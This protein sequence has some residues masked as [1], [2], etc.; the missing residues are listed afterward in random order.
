[1]LFD[2]LPELRQGA[3]GWQGRRFPTGNV[4]YITTLVTL[5]GSACARPGIR[6]WELGRLLVAG[7]VGHSVRLMCLQVCCNVS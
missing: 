1:M 7:H 3:A 4:Y 5:F 6:V 2:S